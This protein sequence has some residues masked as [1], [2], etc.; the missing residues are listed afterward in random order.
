MCAPLGNSSVMQPQCWLRTVRRGKNEAGQLGDN[1]L[2]DR[3]DPTV[4]DNNRKFSA[5]ASG[6]MASHTLFLPW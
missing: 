4:V 5:V 6:P 1:T 3:D 2:E